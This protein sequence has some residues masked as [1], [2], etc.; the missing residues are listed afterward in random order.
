MEY[1]LR[2][3]GIITHV[4]HRKL[5]VRIASDADCAGC[6]V[7]SICSPIEKGPGAVVVEA[8][9]PSEEPTRKFN[10]GDKVTIAISTSG[11]MRAVG[12]S[13]AVPCL[14]LLLCTLSAI[15]LGI[16]QLTAAASGLTAVAVYY[17]MLYLLR[18]HIFANPRWI[19]TE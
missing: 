9:I 11:R 12:L 16:S 10:V 2:H 14:L 15:N 17:L 5:S 19:V 18:K 13:L 4:G 7:K 6:A 1:A 3:H 8:A